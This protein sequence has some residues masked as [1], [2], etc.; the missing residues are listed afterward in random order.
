MRPTARE[1]DINAVHRQR[2]VAHRCPQLYGSGSSPSPSAMRVIAITDI[3]SQRYD[4]ARW[5]AIYQQV[6]AHIGRAA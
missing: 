5:C 1:I 3:I 6:W 4:A 2:L